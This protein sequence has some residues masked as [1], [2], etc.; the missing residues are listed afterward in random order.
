MNIELEPIDPGAPN[1]P[2][3]ISVDITEHRQKMVDSQ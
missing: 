1:L 3:T 2:P